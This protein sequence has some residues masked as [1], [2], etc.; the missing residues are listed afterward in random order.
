MKVSGHLS[1]RKLK[2]PV[3]EKWVHNCFPL[4]VL[5][6]WRIFPY[7]RKSVVPVLGL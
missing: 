5:E 2:L 1:T 6:S 3:N 7:E 4:A